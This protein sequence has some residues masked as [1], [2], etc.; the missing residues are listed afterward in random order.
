ME[1][2]ID[3]VERDE[4]NLVKE[5]V[6]LVDSQIE[7]SFRWVNNKPEEVSRTTDDTR[8]YNQ[9]KLWV[10]KTVY[11]QLTKQVWGIF[12]SSSKKKGASA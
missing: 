9:G 5:V 6:V 1:F 3:R 2:T 10:H 7:I 12:Y 4:R 11:Q 8:L